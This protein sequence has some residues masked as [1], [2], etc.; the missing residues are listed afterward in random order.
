MPLIDRRTGGGVS[1][2]LAARKQS[3]APLPRELWLAII[4]MMAVVG[5]PDRFFVAALIGS[6]AIVWSGGRRVSWE[7]AVAGLGLII[8]LW[9]VGRG[10]GLMASWHPITF[11]GALANVDRW[12]GDPA[13]ALGR[14]YERNAIARA[15][16]T[17]TYDGLPIVLAAAYISTSD[18]A[19][20]I[21]SCL[22]AAAVA[23]VCFQLIPATGPR[24]LYGMEFPWGE[25]HAWPSRTRIPIAFWRNALPSLHFTWAGLSMMA[26]PRRYL[27]LTATFAMFTAIACLATGEH[28]ALDLIVAVPLI[29]AA[30]YI[31]TRRASPGS[32]GVPMQSGISV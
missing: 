20:F 1:A 16:L 18:R 8:G 15:A 4:A 17:A 11:D 14:I 25:A 5:E 23:A 2:R 30:W 32:K 10:N 7:T 3:L 26:A 9:A 13:L 21:S 28:Y 24:Y 6:A 27:P 29:A 19:R 12:I 31:A 22:C